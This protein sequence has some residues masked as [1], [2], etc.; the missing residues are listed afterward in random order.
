MAMQGYTMPVACSQCGELFDISYDMSKGME[1]FL[2]K[3]MSK[4][5][6]KKSTLCWDCRINIGA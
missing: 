1:D 5:S 3:S 2:E 4:K 6:K